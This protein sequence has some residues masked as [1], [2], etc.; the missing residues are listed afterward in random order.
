MKACDVKLVYYTYLFFFIEIHAPACE[1]PIQ[2]RNNFLNFYS[3]TELINNIFDCFNGKPG[4]IDVISFE[5]HLNS[6]IDL[7]VGS[8]CN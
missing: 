2:E 1:S 7:L 4:S 8:L 6:S 5:S 3:R